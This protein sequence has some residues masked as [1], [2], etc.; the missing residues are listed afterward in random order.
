M[1]WHRERHMSYKIWLDQLAGLQ[2]A[3]AQFWRH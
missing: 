3:A 2:P 1:P